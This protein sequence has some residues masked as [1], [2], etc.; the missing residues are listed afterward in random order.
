MGLGMMWNAGEFPLLAA[1]RGS[2]ARAPQL[3]GE[4]MEQCGAKR[5]RFLLRGGRKRPSPLS[6]RTL[7]LLL[8]PA[9]RLQVGRAKAAALPAGVKERRGGGAAAAADE[10]RA[11]A[12]AAAA[13]WTARGAR[14]LSWAA[15]RCAVS[16]RRGEGCAGRGASGGLQGGRSPFLLS[17][18][19]SVAG[20]AAALRSSSAPL[21]PCARGVCG[22]S[23]Q[24][25]Q[26]TLPAPPGFGS[27]ANYN[28]EK[29]F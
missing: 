18:P 1:G 22:A 8:L 21:G 15:G 26:V 13:A 27:S 28:G 7:F 3:P 11:A 4:E 17:P 6:L 24:S 25:R 10:D 29:G 14:Q 16:T 2:A 5:P 23:P 19:A 20:C 9:R 12:A